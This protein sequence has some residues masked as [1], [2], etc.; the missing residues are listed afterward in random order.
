MSSWA[1]R[2]L[3]K[4]GLRGLLWMVVATVLL[5]SYVLYTPSPSAQAPEG[6]ADWIFQNWPALFAA[7]LAM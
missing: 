1:S 5:L 6:A 7:A 3:P 2:G 4:I